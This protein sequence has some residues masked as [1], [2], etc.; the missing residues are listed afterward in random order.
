MLGKTHKAFGVTCVA[1]TA[2][3]YY[4]FTRNH[5]TQDVVYELNQNPTPEIIKH[6]HQNANEY[7]SWLN[8]LLQYFLLVFGALMGSSF[9]DIDQQIPG[10]KHRTWTH[11]IWAIL[12]C[13]GLLHFLRNNYITNALFV[14]MSL[15]IVMLG[16]TIGYISHLLG[17]AFSTSGIDWIYPLIGYKTYSG[18]A[19]VVK[20]FRGPFIPLYS[21]GHGVIGAGFWS[22]IAFILSLYYI[23]QL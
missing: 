6:I 17:D 5:I 14:D 9:P 11:T 8:P 15:V 3:A 10:M 20:G 1:I 18:G 13:I 23:L 21:V 16:F 2:I 19:T 12:L 4:Q 7:T 22:G